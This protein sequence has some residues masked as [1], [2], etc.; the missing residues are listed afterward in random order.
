MTRKTSSGILTLKEVYDLLSEVQQESE[1]LERL[2]TSTATALHEG[3][4]ETTSGLTDAY[5]KFGKQVRK[6]FAAVPL[7]EEGCK[8]LP[9]NS[10]TRDEL[11]RHLN[12]LLH[13]QRK[14]AIDVLNRARHITHNEGHTIAVLSDFH[15]EISRLTDL[16]TSLALMND[17]EDEINALIQGEHALQALMTL[18]EEPD[19]LT[20]DRFAEFEER[21]SARFGKAISVAAVRGKLRFG[22]IEGSPTPAVPHETLCEIQISARFEETDIDGPLP[23]PMEVVNVSPDEQPTIPTQDDLISEPDTDAEEQDYSTNQTESKGQDN[24]HERSESSCETGGFHPSEGSA[25]PQKE[26]KLPECEVVPELDSKTSKLASTAKTVVTPVTEKQDDAVEVKGRDERNTPPPTCS[27]EIASNFLREDA[28]NQLKL[29]EPLLWQLIA[30]DRLGVAHHLGRLA[31]KN[32]GLERLAAIAELASTL[33]LGTAVTSPSGPIVEKITGSIEVIVKSLDAFSAPED[34]PFRYL[35]LLAVLRSAMFAPGT[36]AGLLLERLTKFSF[37]ESYY[38]LLGVVNRL[39]QAGLVLTPELLRGAKDQAAWDEGLRVLQRQAMEALERGRQEKIIYAPAKAVWNYWHDNGQ[40]MFSLLTYVIE[41]RH[42]CLDKAQQEISRWSSKNYVEQKIEITDHHL[43]GKVVRE[44]EARA[45]SKIKERVSETLEIVQT[46]VDHLHGKP[47]DNRDFLIHQLDNLRDEVLSLRGNLTAP[48][49]EPGMVRGL[50]VANDALRKHLSTQMQAFISLFQGNTPG[51][52]AP[53]KLSLLLNRELGLN[54]GIRLDEDWNPLDGKKAERRLLDVAASRPMSLVAYFDEAL[55]RGCHDATERIIKCIALDASPE[56]VNGFS[57]KREESLKVLRFRLEERLTELRIAL[58]QSVISESIAEDERL[59]L[60]AQL[61]LLCADDIVNFEE[62][63]EAV[64]NISVAISRVREQRKQELLKQLAALDVSQQ[65]CEAEVRIRT[66]ID[67]GDLITASDCVEQLRLGEWNNDQQMQASDLCEFFPDFVSRCEHFF[68]QN[69]APLAPDGLKTNDALG[70]ISM[71]GLTEEQRKDAADLLTAWYNVSRAQMSPQGENLTRLLRGLGFSN[72]HIEGQ[73]QALSFRADAINRREICPIPEL[74][75][76]ARGHYE[77]ACLSA[78]NTDHDILQEGGRQRQKGRTSPV[79]VLYFGRL[80]VK[81]RRAIAAQARKGH[82]RGVLILDEYLLLFLCQRTSNRLRSLMAC[83][84]PFIQAEPYITTSGNLPPEMFFGR[85]REVEAIFDPFGSNLVY[86]GRQLGKTVLLREVERRFDNVQSGSLVR[87]IDLNNHHLGTNRSGDDIWDIIADS[88]RKDALTEYKQG[89]QAAIRKGIKTWLDKDPARRIVVLLDE[90]DDFL[91]SEIE[92]RDPYANL[93][94]LKGLMDETGRRFKV[95]FSGLHNVQ[96]TAR[97]PNTPMAHL[98]EPICVGP[99]IRQGEGLEAQRLVREPFRA[100][101]YTFDPPELPL[102]ILGNANRYP[103]LIQLICKALLEHVSDPSR[104][105]CDTQ[106]TPPYTITSKHLNNVLTQRELR[107][108]IADRFY[109]TLRLDPRYCVIALSIALDCLEEPDSNLVHGVDRTTITG[110]ALRFWPKGYGDTSSENL[111]ALLDEMVGL[112]VLREVKPGRY[113]IRS[114]HVIRLL[115]DRDSIEQ[116]LLETSEIEPR[117]RY[118]T[119]TFRRTI[120]NDQLRR[121]P[122]T[123]QQES[124]IFRDSNG[125]ALLFG[126]KASGMDDLL[127]ALHAAKPQGVAVQ[128]FENLQQL[129]QFDRALGTS[130]SSREEGI[131]L[132]VVPPEIKWDIAWLRAGRD[133]IGKLT[134]RDRRVRLLFAGRSTHAWTLATTNSE[135]ADQMAAEPWESYRLKPW[136]DDMVLRWLRDADFGPVDDA[137]G[138]TLIQEAT[139]Y[140]GWCLKDCGERVKGNTHQWQEILQDYKDGLTVEDVHIWFGINEQALEPLEVLVQLGEDA[141]IEDLPG[142][143]DCGED[144]ARS[145]VK[146]AEMMG[147]VRRGPGGRWSVDPWLA[148]W[149][150]PPRQKKN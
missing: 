140:W 32:H 5:T 30:D 60:V 143:V 141:R 129:A 93:L 115:G 106:K 40:P 61:E 144:L 121:S 126:E 42:A 9:S 62:A 1:H 75:S 146:W 51:T 17:A 135:E 44:I 67:Q 127:E 81:Q 107:T 53:T 14:P 108:A 118:Q 48:A 55:N 79:L 132:I 68:G 125:V 95:V 59:D 6:L 96:R 64:R 111:A 142:L 101:G 36:N 24:E 43:R 148:S 73:G 12:L 65:D 145:T 35:T 16:A 7:L 31:A 39:L 128:V 77:L 33:A 99:L 29:W 94:H 136:E 63:D 10:P 20:D 84:S 122:I 104:C 102:T 113:T 69:P 25:T 86:G 34:A 134:S 37:T 41:N 98:G 54:A 138:R 13:L 131:S 22:Q 15:L 85:E 57:R 21:V 103:S 133:R 87:Y 91:V 70:P 47:T 110:H 38:N 71:T 90:A 123:A 100:L 23:M 82:V 112:G 109:L 139:G 19:I 26:S 150:V 18:I 50:Q 46:W 92:R 4:W 11:S 130:L 116:H 45:I 49:V 78:R 76:V 58:E 83:C 149:L 97:D 66:L 28:S 147:Y 114:P 88:L 119:E 120:G 3:R 27:W 8:P 2:L 52:P 72:P 80:S 124:L 117:P 56:E 74:G 89:G 105:A 137:A